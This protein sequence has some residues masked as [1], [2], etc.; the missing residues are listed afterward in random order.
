MLR[1]I[2]AGCGG[3]TF[4]SCSVLGKR[5]ADPVE[6]DLAVVF[7]FEDQ[8]EDTVFRILIE[9][10]ASFKNSA[11][12]SCGFTDE[13][14]GRELVDPCKLCRI[15]RLR[16]FLRTVCGRG[17][18]LRSLFSFRFQDSALGQDIDQA[19]GTFKNFRGEISPAVII[20][21]F[22]R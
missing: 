1:I 8:I 16:F 9:N 2:C 12:L 7:L 18:S 6:G 4:H 19:V 17:R 5:I 21:V 15:S 10:T 3:I 13:I 22:L 14:Q 11:G 20:L